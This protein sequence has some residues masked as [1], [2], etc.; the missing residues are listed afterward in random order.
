[1]I[2]LTLELFSEKNTCGKKS[3]IKHFELYFNVQSNRALIN[4]NTFAT[5]TKT[6]SEIDENP[7]ELEFN[8]QI[9]FRYLLAIELKRFRCFSV[10]RLDADIYQST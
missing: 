4:P 9:E 7:A 3:V 2:Q 5:K 6:W 8:V 1:M 10:L